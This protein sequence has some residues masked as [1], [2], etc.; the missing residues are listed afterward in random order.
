MNTP[1]I[2]P[3]A[4][5]NVTTGIDVLWEDHDILVCLKPHGYLSEGTQDISQ[6][7][8]AALLA[9]QHLS[10]LYPVHRLDRPTAGVMVYA[11]TRPAAAALCAQLQNEKRDT[12]KK[13]YLAVIC[14]IPQSCCG[15][16]SDYL[17]RDP[18]TAKAYVTTHQRRAAKMAR[19]SYQILET[20]NDTAFSFPLTLVKV[21][22]YTGRFHQIR[23]QFA[24]RGMPIAG[25]GKYGSRYKCRAPALFAYQLSF[26]HPIT[27]KKLT[28]C[29][30]PPLYD[31][32]TRFDC[33]QNQTNRHIQTGSSVS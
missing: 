33:L 12:W 27:E 17:Y 24:S 20:V 22:L 6:E 18:N 11:K 21:H 2:T 32:W 29:S 14:G 23:V 15:E 5:S 25:D 8:P 30:P 26:L 16:L 19:L 1:N 3:A 13:E 31:P 7:L 10:V 28:F 9:Q 4:C